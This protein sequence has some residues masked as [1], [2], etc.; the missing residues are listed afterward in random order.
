MNELMKN[1]LFAL[2]QKCMLYIQ[3]LNNNK[4]SYKKDGSVVTEADIYLS[5]FISNQLRQY[6]PRIPIISEEESLNIK[7]LNE[8]TFWLIDPIDGTSSFARGGTGYTINIA[9]VE[10]GVP[11]VGIIGHPPKNTIWYGHGNK[12]LLKKNGTLLNL[13]VV[14]VPLDKIRIVLSY[15]YDNEIKNLLSKIKNASIKNYSSSIKFCKLAEGE[16]DFYPRIQSINKWDIAAGD[17]IL[18]ASGGIVLNKNG[19]IFNY[20]NGNFTTGSFFALSSF[21]LWKKLKNKVLL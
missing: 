16:A 7:I 1:Y 21:Q 15:H 11:V 20:S 3:G 6:Y 12:A 19:E 2:M 10:K 18:R 9:L 8:K 13:N 5:K 14:S 4:V 17:A